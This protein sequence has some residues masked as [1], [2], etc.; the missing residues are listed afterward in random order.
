MYSSDIIPIHQTM[1]HVTV[2]VATLV[3][4]LDDAN[5]P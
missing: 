4:V 2:V 3:N 5:H 1:F